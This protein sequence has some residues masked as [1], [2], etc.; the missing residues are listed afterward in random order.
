M[1]FNINQFS[2]NI[3]T[4]GTLRTSKFDIN[5]TPPRILLSTG[6]ISGL[7]KFRAEQ[8]N[9][10]S[11]NL[12]LTSVNRYGIGP[13]QRFVTN[14]SYPE[15]VSIS[16]VEEETG[17]I[18]RCMLHWMNSIFSFNQEQPLYTT[19]VLKTPYIYVT[20][21]KDEIATIIE[22]VQYTDDA[23]IGN[24]IGILDAFP[25]NLSVSPLSWADSNSLVKVKVEFAFTEWRNLNLCTEEPA[26]EERLTDEQR[27]DMER[28]LEEFRNIPQP[29]ISNTPPVEKSFQNPTAETPTKKRPI[30]LP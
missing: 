3:N 22:V 8:I 16:F 4:Y 24:K 13:K 11:V 10:P 21:Y 20:Q 1:A 28:S 14:V 6:N 9:L 19:R 5:I 2:S 18:Q 17:M 27:K 30:I 26:K 29:P 23:R 25:V 15:T 12:D 7:I